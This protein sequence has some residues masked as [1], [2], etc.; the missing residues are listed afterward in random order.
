M[1]AQG[2]V[3]NISRGKQ[4]G[5]ITPFTLV[6]SGGGMKGLAHVGVFQALDERGLTPAL[7]VGSSMGSLVG[8]A[9]A[10]G[11][12]TDEMRA[13]ALA[14][15]RRHVFKVAHAD[16]ALRRMLSP[17]VYRREPLEML[18]AELVG[19]CNLRDVRRRLLI[20]TV[21]I[22]SGAQVAWGVPGFDDAPLADV[23]FASCA[24]PGIFPPR[25]IRGRWYVDGAVLENLPVRVAA[26]AASW[27]ILAV[28][29]AATSVRRADIE[30]QGFAATYIRGLEIVMQTQIEATLRH[31][32]GPPLVLV[33]PPVE[34]ISMFAFDRTAELLDAGYAATLDALDRLGCRLDQL[35]PGLHP[36]RWVRVQVDETRCVGCGVCAA[37]APTVF[38]LGRRGKA[39]V[40]A[41]VQ[42]WSPLDEACVQGC[43]SGAITLDPAEPATAA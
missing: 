15:Q 6:L 1:R 21:D 17:A 27:P 34:D 35:G 31:W 32:K 10:C 8:A 30:K 38:R 41:P 23:V 25:E 9:W 24:L 5:Q 28:N 29:V 18:I 37:Q 7:V 33:Q 20:N 42:Q 22:N 4:V 3:A 2:Y 12:P 19:E 43:P 11:I 39:H 14:V 26:A 36:T 16:M 40:L 13:R